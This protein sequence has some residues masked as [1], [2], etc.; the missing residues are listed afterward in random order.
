[1]TKEE[2][3]KMY[4]E[5][6][7]YENEIT[8]HNE[9]F[10]K[11]LGKKA[12]KDFEELMDCCQIYEKITVVDAPKGS[13]Q[14]ENCGIYKDIHV[15]QWCTNMEGDSYA[16]FIYAKVKGQWIEVPYYC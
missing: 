3:D 12:Q 11:S 7:A 9:Q 15:D 13:K 4:A 10:L 8:E 16:G 5:L 14:D 6:A 1:M 2:I